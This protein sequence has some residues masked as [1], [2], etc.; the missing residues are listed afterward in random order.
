M[1]V[2]KN[3]EQQETKTPSTGK[4]TTTFRKSRRKAPGTR[5]G[6]LN[7]W[8]EGSTQSGIVSSRYGQAIRDGR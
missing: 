4:L 6:M 3:V 2:K 1:P 7:D 5:L 8:R